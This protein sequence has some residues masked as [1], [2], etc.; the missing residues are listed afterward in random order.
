MDLSNLLVTPALGYLRGDAEQVQGTTG[1]PMLLGGQCRAQRDHGR[2]HDPFV[3]GNLRPLV[4]DVLQLFGVV[5]RE[6][7][8]FLA[9]P[10]LDPRVKKLRELEVV[11]YSDQ[12]DPCLGQVIVD[13]GKVIEHVVPG[14]VDQLVDLIQDDDNDPVLL[15]DLLPKDVVDPFR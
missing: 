15:I 13:L 5:R 9:K 10:A 3:K 1:I 14:L 7:H 2:L 12:R 8:L 6:D 11:R 4:Q